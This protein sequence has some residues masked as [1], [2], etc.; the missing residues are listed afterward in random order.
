MAPTWTRKQIAEA[1][2]GSSRSMT[3]PRTRRPTSAMAALMPTASAGSTGGPPLSARA[4]T[5]GTRWVRNPTC[6]RS[7]KAKG[8][9]MLQKCH[10]RSG[11][12][13]LGLTVVALGDSGPRRTNRA[14]VP[15]AMTMPIRT[16]SRSA[17][18]NPSAG[19][20]ASR[21]GVTARPATVAP[22][23]AR[24]RARPRLRSNHWPTVAAIG[25]TLVAFQ[26]GAMT[27]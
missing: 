11:A 26:P 10:C 4:L 25:A 20:A 21:T 13:R 17:V 18:A 15:A 12:R 16:R 1:R 19:I 27:M 5:S 22:L 2:R 23:S 7:T 14:T 6:D 9:E 24:L 3:R 8:A